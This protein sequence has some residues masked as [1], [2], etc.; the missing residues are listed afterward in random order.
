MWHRGKTSSSWWSKNEFTVLHGIFVSHPLLLTG[1]TIFKADDD[2]DD[3]RRWFTQSVS[4]FPDMWSRKGV[5]RDLAFR[6]VICLRLTCGLLGYSD[7][8]VDSALTFESDIRQE[9]KIPIIKPFKPVLHE[10]VFHDRFF[11][12]G[13]K[14][15]CRKEKETLSPSRFPRWKLAVPAFQRGNTSV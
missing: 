10:H 13:K 15:P 7:G 11:L 2:G 8:R 6:I 1:L 4:P 3:T 14:W 12:T 5:R 9:S